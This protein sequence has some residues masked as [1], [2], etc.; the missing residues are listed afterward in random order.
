MSGVAV[1]AQRSSRV[2]GART[3]PNLFERDE[4]AV[5]ALFQCDEPEVTGGGSVR[6]VSVSG[7]LHSV[8]KEVDDLVDP[9]GVDLD[10][11]AA[12]AEPSPVKLQAAPVQATP[13]KAPG[14]YAAT[15]VFAALSSA[16]RYSPPPGRACSW[17]CQLQTLPSRCASQAKRRPRAVYFKTSMTASLFEQRFVSRR[18]LVVAS[19]ALARGT[20]A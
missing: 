3:N 10:A 2:P 20:A 6:R 7:V 13:H 11:L 15:A 12:S 1:Q 9:L 17:I 18:R 8:P 16:A 14:D 4:A 5:D 19:F